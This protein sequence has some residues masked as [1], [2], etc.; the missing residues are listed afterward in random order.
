MRSVD[1][2]ALH[3]YTYRLE[4]DHPYSI[5]DPR[6]QYVQHNYR[7]RADELNKVKPHFHTTYQRSYSPNNSILR[8]SKTV[9]NVGSGLTPQTQQ[10]LARR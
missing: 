9:L 1:D 10:P 3:S 7:Y 2:P 8:R 5:N 4:T 6:N